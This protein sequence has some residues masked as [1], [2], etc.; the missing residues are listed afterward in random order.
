MRTVVLQS[1]K[2]H[3]VPKWIES[4]LKSVRNWC[5]SNGYEYVF[6]GDEFLETCP[7]W[8]RKKTKAHKLIN[9]DL[10]RLLHIKKLLGSFDRAIWIDADV[11]VFSPSDLSIPDDESYLFC[12]ET[13][14]DINKDNRLIADNNVNNSIMA[15]KR[16]NPVLDFYIHACIEIVKKTREDLLWHASIGTKF[17]TSLYSELKFPLVQNV[18]ISPPVIIDAIVNRRHDL[19]HFY[20]EYHNHSLCAV[21]LCASFRDKDYQGFTLND[22][23]YEL[24]CNVLMS[25][26]NRLMSRQPSRG[27]NESR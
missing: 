17:L 1:F 23:D 18:G 4:C 13:Y 26:G 7:K 21:N 9:T 12:K 10:S 25:Q 6:I 15:F 16:T 8:F 5:L 11:L 3:D 27:I 24:A 19:L 22:N 14:I 20:L 2:K